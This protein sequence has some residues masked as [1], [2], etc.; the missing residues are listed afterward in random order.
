M[1]LS[2]FSMVK[3]AESLY[4][5]I[6]QA[7]ESV[8]PIVDEFVLALGDN[9]TD[10]QTEEIIAS[11]KSP[12]LRVVRT[13]WDLKK[14]PNGTENA[15]QTDIAK[16]HCTGDWLIYV[17]ADEVVHEEDHPEILAQCTKHLDNKKVEGFIF[18]YRHFWG[19]YDHFH[20]AHNWYKHEV[21]IIRNDPEI[22]S[23][24]SAQSFRRIPHFSGENYR[25]QEGTHKLKVI[26]LNAY[27]YHYGW[28]RPPH[29][30][31]KKKKALD[32]IHKGEKITEELYADE[33]NKFEYGP[34]GRLSKFKGTHPR[35]MQEWIKKLDW[36]N[37]LNYSKEI[38]NKKRKTHKHEK[39]KT[40]ITTFLEQKLLKGRTIGGFKNYIRLK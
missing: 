32:T 27:I 6:K 26:S 12:K 17:Q 35:V 1:K 40:R 31:Q 28:V 15:H 20:H 3:N 33:K 8:L 38:K 14:Y 25:Q 24:E 30:M 11:I 13:V 18:K 39:L 2:G 19:D 29:L 7:I 16:S 5:P 9:N 36:K 37:E 10:D 4:F 22:H 21:R 34:L 23:W